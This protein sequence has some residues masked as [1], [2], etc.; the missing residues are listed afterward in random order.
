M[1]G[2]S[3]TMQMVR[4]LRR[5]A[6]RAGA[7]AAV[8]AACGALAQSD[9]LGAALAEEARSVAEG[10]VAQAEIDALSEDQ[11]ALLAD[12]RGK[13]QEL[14]RLD[15]YNRHLGGLVAD[16]GRE[17][18]AMDADL[19]AALVVQQ[20][21]VPLLERM[22]DHLD[23]FVAADLPVRAARRAERVAGLRALMSDSGVSTA[24]KYRQI[25]DAYKIEMELGRTIEAW[26]GDVERE[27]RTLAVHYL[28]VGRL[29]LAYQSEDRSVTAFWNT[30]ASPPG[31]TDLPEADRYHVD[32]ALRIANKQSAPALLV[33]PVPAPGT[34]R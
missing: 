3:G 27:G 24:E 28:A 16:Q 21:I 30:A 14:E 17:L 34:P 15:A 6:R 7:A 12:Y 32:A 5:G 19:E 9:P 2:N 29:V 10:R 26:P 1:R 8:V 13:R 4:Q 18:A 31:W 25:M 23:A 33:L 22:I 20:E 11:R